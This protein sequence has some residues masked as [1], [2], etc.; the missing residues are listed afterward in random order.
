MTGD[1]G[2]KPQRAPDEASPLA[3]TFISF[4][5]TSI[6]SLVLQKRTSFTVEPGNI[7]TQAG[8]DQAEVLR[9]SGGHVVLIHRGPIGESVKVKDTC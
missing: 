5:I 8:S 1:K 4:T 6:S 7:E 9:A 2:P 3:R